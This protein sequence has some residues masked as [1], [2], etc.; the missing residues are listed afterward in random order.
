MRTLEQ[1]KGK[2]AEAEVLAWAS[3]LRHFY[4]MGEV[5]SGQMELYEE[6]QM[7]LNFSGREDLLGVL[8]ALGLLRY[9]VGEPPKQ[10][11]PGGE[12]RVTDHPD[13]VQPEHCRVAGSA[14]FAY[15]E[16]AFIDMTCA[17]DYQVA[18]SNVQDALRIESEIDRLQL[19]SRVNRKIATHANC[20]SAANFPD[21]FA[22]RP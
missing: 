15:V 5:S 6:L 4:F 16:S 7:R 18:D 10:W 14:C 8:G 20:I 21:R 1:L 17:A 22:R 19:Q 2:H 9:G 12:S 13:L 11:N 3:R